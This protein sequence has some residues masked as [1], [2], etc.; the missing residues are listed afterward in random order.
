M[1]RHVFTE[2]EDKRNQILLCFVRFFF[3]LRLSLGVVSFCTQ[4]ISILRSLFV[5]DSKHVLCW[6]IE[7]KT[8]DDRTVPQKESLALLS[9]KRRFLVGRRLAIRATTTTM[10]SATSQQSPS[11]SS[12]ATTDYDNTTERTPIVGRITDFIE[13]HDLDP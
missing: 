13:L 3:A 8:S 9:A 10:K 5:L 12:I 11:I 2:I 4:L 7:F 6:R 1:S